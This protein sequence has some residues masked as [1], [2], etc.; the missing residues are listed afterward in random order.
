MIRGV[1]TDIAEMKNE[2]ENIEDFIHQADKMADAEG[3]NT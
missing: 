3:D 2:L 1:P